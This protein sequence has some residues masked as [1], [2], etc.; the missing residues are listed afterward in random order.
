[1]SNLLC[2][3]DLSIEFARPGGRTRVVENLSF[4]MAPGER[5]AL[6]G[7]S[8]SGKTVS[9][10]AVMRLNPDAHY[11]GR[12]V[13]EGRDLLQ[14]SEREM[15]GVRGNRIAMIFQ[16]PMTALN[17]LYPIGNQ[18]CETLELHQGMSRVQARDKAI[19]LLGRTGI[20]EP[21]RR[22]TSFAHQLSGGQRQRAMIAMALACNPA[23]LIAD[24]PTTALDV[25]IQRQI[26]E[27]LAELQR[28]FGM[29]V[30][31]ITHDLPL[32]RSFADRVGVMQSG[33]LVETGTT[34][35]I[36]SQPAD[37]YTRR[38]IDSRPRRMLD[39]LPPRSP[40]VLEARRVSCDFEFRSGLFGRRRFRAVNQVDLQLGRGETLGIVG[41]SGSGK[42]TLGMSLLRLAR[43]RVQGEVDLNGTRID[44]LSARALRPLRKLVQVVFQDPYNSLSPRMTVEGIVGEGL[45]LHRPE[46][47]AGERREA[48]VQML[49]EVGLSAEMMDR[50]P[51]EFSGG[52]RQRIA[53][54]RAV[55]LRPEVLLLDEPTSALD[56][57]VQ[58]QVLE[59]LVHL[60]RRHGLSYL[61][62][63]H[64]LAVIRAMAH[65]VM[66][67]KDGQVIE[68]GETES[69]FADPQ[70]DYTRSLL[71]AALS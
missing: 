58:Q 13:F 34:E 2:I 20:P 24:E 27:L 61:F 26:V 40:C 5:F 4:S 32:V 1:M 48:I 6:V 56:V 10:L 50:Y 68:A 36:F 52:Q 38:L 7:E 18:I 46:L 25:T 19:E 59:L 28:E 9:S 67:M 35:Q 23:L 12:I 65:R 70:H 60:Q 43:G 69:L 57:S 22:F 37:P 54:A 3:E 62:I 11:Q 15:R 71:A 16:E 8:G 44:T 49:E 31:L 64:D 66:V 33:R 42:T 45:A 14:V 51:H 47:G 17:P 41:E 55:V 53:I 29:A 30:L 21:A 39:S 63:T